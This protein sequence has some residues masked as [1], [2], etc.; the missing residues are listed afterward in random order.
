MGA[1]VSRL[2]QCP[3][4]DRPRSEIEV[5]VVLAAPLGGGKR[6]CKWQTCRTGDNQRPDVRRQIHDYF[7]ERVL[8]KFCQIRSRGIARY[9]MLSIA[10]RQIRPSRCRSVQSALVPQRLERGPE[11]PDVPFYE[12]GAGGFAYASARRSNASEIC[13][14]LTPSAD[15][16]MT[17]DLG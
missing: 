13:S 2:V 4:M 14:N 3:D 16:I 9:A 15:W 10:R 5:H 12:S 11:I 6:Y 7:L 8:G 17:K 1:V